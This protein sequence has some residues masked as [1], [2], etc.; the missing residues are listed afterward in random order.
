MPHNHDP[1]ER[2]KNTNANVLIIDDDL[3]LGWD[4]DWDATRIDRIYYAYA[5]VTLMKRPTW[6]DQQS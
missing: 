4:R 1:R 2:P 6:M 3:G 5:A